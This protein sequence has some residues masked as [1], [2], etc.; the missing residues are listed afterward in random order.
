MFVV[1]IILLVRLH[2]LRKVTLSA[3]LVVAGVGIGRVV[4]DVAGQAFG[5]D[6][7][8]AGMVIVGGGSG[9]FADDDLELFAQHTLEQRKTRQLGGRCV[10]EGFD[11]TQQVCARLWQATPRSARRR[12]GEAARALAI[13]IAFD[14]VG[15][16]R[17]VKFGSAPGQLTQEL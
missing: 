2:H 3:V 16:N 12:V 1:A 11:Q 5:L 6:D 17:V 15:A 7:T 4:Q 10:T 14:Q 9:G 8:D 13:H